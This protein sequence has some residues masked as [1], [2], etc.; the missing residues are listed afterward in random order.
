MHQS[1]HVPRT[2]PFVFDLPPCLLRRPEVLESE[3]AERWTFPLVTG[4]SCVCVHMCAVRR[5]KPH[6][7]RPNE[8]K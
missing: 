5:T 8:P 4:G 3:T 2:A 7:A 1:H 6:D